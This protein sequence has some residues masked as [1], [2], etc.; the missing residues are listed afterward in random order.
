MKLVTSFGVVVLGMS[1]Y[2]CFSNVEPTTTGQATAESS[3]VVPVII[4]LSYQNLIGEDLSGKDLSGANL[5]GA[6]MSRANLQGANLSGAILIG[7]NL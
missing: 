3:T 5:E 7:A 2:E 4:D 1:L 6:N